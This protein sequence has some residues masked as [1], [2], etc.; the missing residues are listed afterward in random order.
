[1]YPAPARPG[2][3]WKLLQSW[4]VLISIVGIGCLS[5]AGFVLIGL[6][7]RKPGWWGT[8]VAYM[9]VETA[10]FVASDRVLSGTPEHLDDTIVTAWGVLWL[11]SIVHSFVLNVFWLRWREQR[12]LATQPQPFGVPAAYGSPAVPFGSPVAPAS[13]VPYSGAPYQ[14]PPPVGPPAT[15]SI[16]FPAQCQPPTAGH[17]PQQYPSQP[18]SLQFPA[19][20]TGSTTP[21]PAPTPWTPN[22]PVD[23]NIADAAQFSTLEAFDAA[24]VAHV[25]SERQRRGGY[26][27]LAEFAATAQLTPY[28]FERI[29]HRLALS[30]PRRF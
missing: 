28:Q 13:A 22:G 9:V 14:S 5:G 17:V 3:G 4:W 27:S 8:G 30:P 2:F 21:W 29:Q 20:T 16:G 6:R 23:V 18:S 1:M 7:A 15:G 11:V 10:L 25:L 12:Y 19:A 24:R 26:T